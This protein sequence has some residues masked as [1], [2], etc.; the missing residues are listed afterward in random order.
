[1][2]IQAYRISPGRRQ[3]M[4]D[5]LEEQVNQGLIEKV[6]GHTEWA[7]PAFLVEKG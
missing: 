6:K 4:A 1:M 2:S 7:S 3:I 5:L